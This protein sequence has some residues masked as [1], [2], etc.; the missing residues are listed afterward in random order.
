MTEIRITSSRLDPDTNGSEQQ[1]SPGGTDAQQDRDPDRAVLGLRI[2]GVRDGQLGPAEEEARAEEYEDVDACACK[3]L[4]VGPDAGGDGDV[5]D[6]PQN[7]DADDGAHHC[8]EDPRPV[9]SAAGRDEDEEERRGQ[10]AQRREDDQQRYR[11]LVH[12]CAAD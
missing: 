7:V 5:G 12:D 11:D 3:P 6:V 9:V 8:W 4:L 10:E 2:G 1:T